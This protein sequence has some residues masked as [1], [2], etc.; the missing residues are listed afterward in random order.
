MTVPFLSTDR[1]PRQLPVPRHPTLMATWPSESIF[2][3]ELRILSVRP[4][5]T[6]G[7]LSRPRQPV[8]PTVS[9]VSSASALIV[10]NPSP[11]TTM[12]GSA[13]LLATL[14]V[15]LPPNPSTKFG[16]PGAP[17]RTSGAPPLPSS[18][19][20]SECALAPWFVTPSLAALSSDTFTGA[21]KP[22]QF[23]RSLPAPP[24]RF[25]G[26]PPGNRPSSPSSPFSTSGVGELFWP[27][28]PFSA[29]ASAPPF[30]IADTNGGFS[31]KNRPL[32]VMLSSPAPPFAT[33]LSTM[34]IVSLPA[35]PLPVA[36]GAVP[37]TVVPTGRLMVSL[38]SPP[39]S[40]NT[41][42]GGNV[43]C[44]NSGPEMDPV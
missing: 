26:P 7:L 36:V 13:G 23:T 35:S 24:L 27:P 43:P 5:A 9:N 31:P 40:V 33:S 18:V 21:A 1:T 15:S 2:V 6:G 16:T 41:S 38:P 42:P 11:H 28:N 34:L 37:L 39:L 20:M 19:S 44:A 4:L 14:N 29:S 8:G 10:T 22:F 17:E 12:S 32:L 30:M 3:D 25:S